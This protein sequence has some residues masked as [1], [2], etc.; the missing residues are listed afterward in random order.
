[1]LGKEVAALVNA[2]LNAGTYKYN[3]DASLLSSGVYFYKLAVDGN[4]V[5][6]KR[7]VLLK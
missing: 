5:D 3:F 6:T 7:M 4:I 1:M 2:K